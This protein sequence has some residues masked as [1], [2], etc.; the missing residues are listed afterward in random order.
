VTWPPPRSTSFSAEPGPIKT[1]RIHVDMRKWPDRK[2]WQFDSE[3]LGEDDFGVWLYTAQGSVIQRGEEQPISLGS[4]FVGLVPRDQWW[5]AEF[6]W[7]HPTQ[8]IY[9]N[10]GTPCE[11]GDDRVTSIDLDLDVV[12]HLDG[13]VEVL[14]EDEFLDHQVR[15]A[16][17][18][19]LIETARV[20]ATNAVEALQRGD[21][22]F[23]TAARRWL[24]RV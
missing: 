23:R 3:M 10:I 5:L 12:R 21:E 14:D 4:G 8:E 24:A 20:T 13:S 1:S 11:W 22:P 6:Y 15:H 16:Y 2:H 9:V 18:Q 17:P 7:D 19:H